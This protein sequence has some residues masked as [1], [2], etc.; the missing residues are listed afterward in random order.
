MAGGRVILFVITVN[1]V[2]VLIRLVYRLNAQ[3]YGLHVVGFN[4]IPVKNVVT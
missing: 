1:H 2:D 4:V 3:S